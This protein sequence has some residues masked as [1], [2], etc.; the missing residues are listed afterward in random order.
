MSREQNP[1]SGTPFDELD[2]IP[3]IT[4][5]RGPVPFDQ[6]ELPAVPKEQQEAWDWA[7]QDPEVRARYAGRIILVHNRKVWGAGNSYQAALEQALQK[8][9]CPPEDELIDVMV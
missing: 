6:V 9:G 3:G 1:A 5:Y 2:L 7:M 8:P 4:R